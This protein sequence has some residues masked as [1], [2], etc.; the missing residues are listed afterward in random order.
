MWLRLPAAEV[1]ITGKMPVPHVWIVQ[2][3]VLER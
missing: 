2:G 1:R 3:S